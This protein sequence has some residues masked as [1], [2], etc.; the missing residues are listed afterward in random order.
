MSNE[1][2]SA[3]AV[4]KILVYGMTGNIGGLENYIMYQYRQFDKSKI[5]IDFISAYKDVD[6]I[7]FQDEILDNGSKI[8]KL[9]T[10]PLWERFLTEH[11]GEYHTIIFNN[12]NPLELNMLDL[13]KEKGG[14]RRIIIH[15]H[16][17]GIDFSPL[18]QKMLRKR[19]LKRQQ[20]F[21]N[22]GATLWACSELAG[23]WMFGDSAKFT[24]IKNGINTDAFRFDA[25]IR[26]EVRKEL[27]FTDNDFVI[28]NVA[29]FAFQK[30]HKFMIS[31]FKEISKDMPDAKLV[32]IGQNSP[33][34]NKLKELTQ[35]RVF[36]KGVSKNVR[37][38]GL[39]KDTA[40]LYQ[41]MDAFILPSHYEGLPVVGVEAQCSG[42]PCFFSDTITKEAKLTTNTYYLP[43]QPIRPSLQT[44]K[45]EILRIS[46][47]NDINR[48][49]AFEVIKDKGFDIK[50]ETKRVEILLLSDN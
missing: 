34:I 33:A 14:F 26:Q 8:F 3:G 32:L 44:W 31:L 15:S 47:R 41:A 20:D 11:S 28:G 10:I 17:G 27:G 49:M 18:I 23:K 39:R 25:R 22:I 1:N 35:I 9:T 50:D 2:H 7:A 43:I 42:L 24:I 5:H 4:R 46:R 29:R 45:D 30:N 16:N 36:L 37:F 21:R 48:S 19:F 12:T 40:R 13:V 6:K 38:L